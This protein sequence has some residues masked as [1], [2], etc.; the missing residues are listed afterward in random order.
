VLER[1]AVDLLVTDV[2]MPGMNGRELA[3]TARR[4]RPA[5]KVLY[6]SG[7]TDDEVLARGVMRGEVEMLDK[8]FRVDKLAAKIRE[9][10]D[11][12]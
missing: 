12:A 10:L 8:P 3:E 1:E 4:S 11:A 9:V 5:L 6:T 2:V 7:Y